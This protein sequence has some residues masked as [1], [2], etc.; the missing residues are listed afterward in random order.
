MEIISNPVLMAAIVSSSIALVS[1]LAQSIISNSKKQREEK[2]YYEKTLADKMIRVYSPLLMLLNNRK[3]DDL[4]IDAEVELIIRQDGHL[5]SISRLEE[6]QEIIE[7]ESRFNS[8]NNQ[9]KSEYQFLREKLVFE[10]RSEYAVLHDAYN[11]GFQAYQKKYSLPFKEWLASRAIRTFG[12]S[13][14]AF[15]VLFFASDTYSSRLVQGAMF[16]WTTI[17]I[18]VTYIFLTAA[19]SFFVQINRKS[20]SNLFVSKNYATEKAEYKCIACGIRA[21]R[22]K[23]QRLGECFNTHRWPHRLKGHLAR[24]DWKKM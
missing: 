4:M 20:A 19:L 17:S 8:L 13:T 16:I 7:I 11:R 18:A 15:W 24:F 3:R 9:E 12:F 5:L 14:I 2:I 10:F 23:N 21:E 22:L 1:G 6:F